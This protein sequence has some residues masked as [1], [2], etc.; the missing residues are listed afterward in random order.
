MRRS[1]RR[2]ASR[3]TARPARD[4]ASSIQLCVADVEP[5]EAV[6]EH[7]QHRDDDRQ[8]QRPPEAA[9]KIGELGVLVLV[10]RRQHRLERH[11]ADRAVARA[12]PGGSA[13]ASGR[14]RS[15]RWRCRCSC[16]SGGAIDDAPDFRARL[17]WHRAR[18]SSPAD[19][20][21]SASSICIMSMPHLHHLH[22]CSRHRK[23]SPSAPASGRPAPPIIL[24]PCST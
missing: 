16:R 11:A 13:G 1:A 15:P 24:L 22:L 14:C 18:L 19:P 2:T 7:R 10:E 23:A 9:A 12:G 6:A 20:S 4:S 17:A 5:G 3:P 21:S 8:R